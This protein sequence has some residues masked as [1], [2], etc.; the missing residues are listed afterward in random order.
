M[1]HVATLIGPSDA[2]DASMLAR[3]RAELPGAAEP[4]RLG[5]GAADIPFSV[6]GGLD[7]RAIA[8]QLR[9]VLNASLDVVVQPAAN[10]RKKLFLADMD[11]T[12]IGQE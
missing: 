10:R 3:A 12:M 5:P 2:L 6:R 8:A 1:T 4:R 9:G 7:Q 11:S